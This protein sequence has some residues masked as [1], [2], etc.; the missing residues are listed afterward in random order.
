MKIETDRLIIVPW[1]NTTRDAEALYNW[2]KNPNVGPK[3]GWKPHESIEESMNIIKNIFIPVGAFK[4]ILKDKKQVIGNIGFEPD[5][6]REGTSSME[7]GYALDESYWN[8][9]YMT[10]AVKAVIDYAF[11]ELGLDVLSI[12]TNI[13]NKASQ[14][15]I[16]K[17]GFTYEGFRRKSSVDF[18]G[19]VRDIN[20][21]SMLREEWQKMK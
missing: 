5:V 1:E 19:T 17:V 16:E 10:E 18:D 4:I 3:A 13:V 11:D 15:V 2:A 9:G 8:N 14:K 7:M 21:Y 20:M 12:Q 6:H